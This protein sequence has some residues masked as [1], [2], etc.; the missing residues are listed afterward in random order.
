MF[1]C[2]PGIRTLVGTGEEHKAH[3]AITENG[4]II[5]EFPYSE[6]IPNDPIQHF[7]GGL[8]VLMPEIRNFFS[9]MFTDVVKLSNNLIQIYSLKGLDGMLIENASFDIPNE[10]KENVSPFTING[11]ELIERIWGNFSTRKYGKVTSLQSKDKNS[12]QDFMTLCVLENSKIIAH[13]TIS[14]FKP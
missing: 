8:H 1:K 10:S 11:F 4:P 6:D 7:R 12:G 3:I 13:L 2:N 9:V 5:I 14:F